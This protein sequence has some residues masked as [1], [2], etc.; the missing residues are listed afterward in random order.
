[1]IKQT[2]KFADTNYSK[3]NLLCR[4]QSKNSKLSMVPS[5]KIQIQKRKS[6]EETSF[7]KGIISQ[8]TPNPNIKMF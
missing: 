3:A 4:L 8:M 7:K 2:E 5:T 6:Q 1:M